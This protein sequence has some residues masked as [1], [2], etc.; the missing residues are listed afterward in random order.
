MKKKKNWSWSI[1][2]LLKIKIYIMLKNNKWWARYEVTK[3]LTK[4]KTT[5]P[6]KD[7]NCYFKRLINNIW[8]I[9]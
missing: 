5:T 1:K 4:T 3:T 2:K 9:L 7:W 6:K 8:I